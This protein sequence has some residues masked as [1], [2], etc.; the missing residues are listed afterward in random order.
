MELEPDQEL[1]VILFLSVIWHS[2]W[3]SRVKSQRPSTYKVRADLEAK[4]N[5][6]RETRRYKDVAVKILHLMKNLLTKYDNKSL[7]RDAFKK[8]KTEI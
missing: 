1:P 4:V 6:L 7:I 5:L 2:I 8:K 3:T